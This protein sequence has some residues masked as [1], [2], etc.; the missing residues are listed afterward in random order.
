MTRTNNSFNIPIEDGQLI[1]GRD[2][3]SPVAASITPGGANVEVTNGAGSITMAV[4][5][6]SFC[7]M[8]H[9]DASIVQ[10]MTPGNGYVARDTVNIAQLL[11]PPTATFG[12]LFFASSS[13]DM[14]GIIPGESQGFIMSCVGGQ[15]VGSPSQPT[16]GVTVNGTTVGQPCSVLV[17]C[18]DDSV[19][20]SEQFQIIS[21][22]GT[23]V[24]G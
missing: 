22:T 3:L 9:A 16:G 15:R 23:I 10:T 13:K 12:D 7:K 8:N 21:P 2:V 19:P 4:P 1:V 17:M 24:I 5:M 14:A 6:A 20:N 11:F 18:V